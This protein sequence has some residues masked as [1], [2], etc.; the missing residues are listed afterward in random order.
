MLV[1]KIN[2]GVPHSVLYTYKIST[3]DGW[4]YI[5]PILLHKYDIYINIMLK[6]HSVISQLHLYKYIEFVVHKSVR[7]GTFGGWAMLAERNTYVCVME[8]E[9]LKAIGIQIKIVDFVS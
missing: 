6:V 4:L 2:Y 1:Y 9:N 5:L 3:R 8:T 7:V